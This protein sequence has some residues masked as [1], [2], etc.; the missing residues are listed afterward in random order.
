MRPG[1]K[2]RQGSPYL[3]QLI[4]HYIVSYAYDGR[5]DRRTLDD[6]LASADEE[7]E[8]DVCATTL[9]GLSSQDRSY[10]VAMAELGDT[11]RSAEVA[12][13][14]GVTPDYAQQYRRRLLDAGVITA[15]F[16]GTVRFCVPHLGDYLLREQRA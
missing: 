14:M 9:A 7:F 4:G 11:C 5:V 8:N 3:M 15:P 13:H 10:L 6:A 2:E 16:R 1:S 12:R